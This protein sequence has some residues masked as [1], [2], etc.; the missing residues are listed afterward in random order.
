MQQNINTMHGPINI[1]HK[2]KIWLWILLRVLFI[3][4]FIKLNLC[5]YKLN[6][7]VTQNLHPKLIA[8]FL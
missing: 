6:K 5:G 2:K 4:M 7:N 8:G 3:Y 1:K